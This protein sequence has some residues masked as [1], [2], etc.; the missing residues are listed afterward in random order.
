MKSKLPLSLAM[1]LAAGSAEAQSSDSIRSIW[2]ANPLPQE[3]VTSTPKPCDFQAFEGIEFTFSND[4]EREQYGFQSFG[5]SP[6]GLGSLPFS[7]Y[8]GKKGK[9]GRSTSARTREVLIE[10]CAVAYLLKDG[11]IRAEDAQGFGITFDS[12]PPTNWVTSEKTDRMTDQKSCTV[13]PGG[14]RMPFPM[15][16]YHSSEGFSVGVVGGD[17]PGRATTFRVDKNRAISE[18]EGLSGRNGAALVAQIRAGGKALLVGSYEWPNDY[19]QVREFN[20]DGLVPALDQCKRSVA[21]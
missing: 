19:E 21:K 18:K 9:I 7:E 10:N 11:D 20:L 14:A 3:T 15:F 17:F 1:F 16:F 12:P 13:T 4:P 2:G 8:A 5:T 6:S